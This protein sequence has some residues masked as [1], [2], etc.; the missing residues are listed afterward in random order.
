[1]NPSDLG[2]IQINPS[3]IIVHKICCQSHRNVGINSLYFV[4]VSPPVTHFLHWLCFFSVTSCDTL[5]SLV[6]LS[7]TWKCMKV[8][9]ITYHTIPGTVFFSLFLS[10]SFFSLYW[11]INLWNQSSSP[12]IQSQSISSGYET[13]A[14]TSSQSSCWH[15]DRFNV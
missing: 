6:L 2:L 5:S 7:C 1:M 9:L 15:T 8:F 13:S 4:Y 14:S 10:L 11:L 3:Y 12:I